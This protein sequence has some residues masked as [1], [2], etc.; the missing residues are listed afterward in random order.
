MNSSSYSAKYELY[1]FISFFKQVYKIHKYPVDT[2]QICKDD[3]T[4]VLCMHNFKT[5]GFCGAAFP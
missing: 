5:I 1:K 2:I 3:D 4:T